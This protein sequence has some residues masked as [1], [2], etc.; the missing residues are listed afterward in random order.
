MTIYMRASWNGY[1]QGTIQNLSVVDEARLVAGNVA[2]YIVDPARMIDLAEIAPFRAQEKAALS[3]GS[4]IRCAS[5]ATIAGQAI[6][7]NATKPLVVR[8]SNN[9]MIMYT[10][11]GVCG[12]AE[13]AFSATSEIVDGTARA[14]ALGQV[15]SP[16][17]ADVPIPEVTQNAGGSPLPV[18]Y[19]V[20]ANSGSFRHPVTPNL[21]QFGSDCLGWLYKSGGSNDPIGAGT[22]CMA[23]K[24]VLEFYSS[25]LMV[26][27]TF[28]P[29]GSGQIERPR[30]RVEGNWLEEVPSAYA[31][32]VGGTKYMRVDY[33]ATTVKAM[34]RWFVEVPSGVRI[35]SISVPSG[36]TIT[37]VRDPALYAILNMDSYGRTVSEKLPANTNIDINFAPSETMIEQVMRDL[38]YRYVL[39]MHEGG[40]GYSVNGTNGRLNVRDLVYLNDMSGFDVRYAIFF[41]GGNDFDGGVTTAVLKQRAKEAW[42]ER[43]R[44]NPLALLHVYGL[45]PSDQQSVAGLQAMDQALLDAFVELNDPNSHFDSMITGYSYAPG[46][47]SWNDGPWVTGAGRQGNPTGVGNS[48]I[49]TG[50][51]SAH[52][53]PPAKPYFRQRM[54]ACGERAHQVRGL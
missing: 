29:G 31:G 27:V 16:P 30:V 25:A 23:Y 14:W 42:R 18:V 4:L 17:P 6:V 22:G 9:Q 36:E 8:L 1:E 45:F 19:N 15:S 44:Q 52:I 38:G 10:T 47:G 11:S 34:R 5:W 46:V 51:D 37:P 26:D 43:R 32:A 21:F 24:Q 54:A 28:F 2:T 39:N 40:T 49:Y 53:S 50:I 20:Y 35:R 48:D 7:V 41:A 12:A 13:P 3:R 33:T